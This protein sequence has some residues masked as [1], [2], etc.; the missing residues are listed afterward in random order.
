MLNSFGSRIT[1]FH[2]IFSK[3]YRFDGDQTLAVVY[4]TPNH[5]MLQLD[6]DRAEVWQLN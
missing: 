1:I 2:G 6:D 4:R 5:L 3:L